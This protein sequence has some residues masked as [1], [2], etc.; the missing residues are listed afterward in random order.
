MGLCINKNPNLM[1]V[2]DPQDPD[3]SPLEPIKPYE[4]M[5]IS[6]SFVKRTFKDIKYTIMLPRYSPLQELY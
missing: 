6:D 5:H 2:Y 1:A 4:S 3:A